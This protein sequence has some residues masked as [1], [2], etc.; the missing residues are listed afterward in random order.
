MDKLVKPTI[1]KYKLG[2]KSI[3]NKTLKIDNNNVSHT[4]KLGLIQKDENKSGHHIITPL[5]KKYLNKQITDKELF[6][7]QMLRF[8]ESEDS[9]FI[10]PYRSFIKIL[11]EV[12]S[13][14]FYEFIFA[15]YTMIDSTESSIQ[16]AIDDINFLRNNYP[17]L[18][19]TS[20]ANQESILGELNAY[21]RTPYTITNLWASTTIKNQF[22]YFKNHLGLFDEI[23]YIDKEGIH[24]KKN[25]TAKARNLLA[26]DN[27][28]EYETDYSKI[29]KKYISAFIKVVIFTI[30]TIRFNKTLFKHYRV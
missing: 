12:K 25:S 9:R 16:E 15:I 17:N 5:G 26:L 27:K 10:F 7:R 23:I 20:Q 8:S 1:Q 18:S 11:L 21:F 29:L 14:S 6:R 3:P 4:R 30:W 19:A 2:Q 28:L 13:I 22:G 24:L